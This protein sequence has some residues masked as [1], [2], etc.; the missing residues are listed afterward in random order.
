MQHRVIQNRLGQHISLLFYF[1]KF[2]QY[3]RLYVVRYIF[4][5]AADPDIAVVVSVTGYNFE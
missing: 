5:T 1:V 4:T 3:L 2:L